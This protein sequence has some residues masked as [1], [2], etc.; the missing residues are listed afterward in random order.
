MQESR[1]SLKPPTDV[2]TCRPSIAFR[3]RS[4]LLIPEPMERETMKMV[5]NRRGLFW[6]LWI[7]QTLFTESLIV[8]SIYFT[9]RT[10]NHSHIFH[11]FYVDM[12]RTRIPGIMTSSSS[13][14]LSISHVVDSC[15]AESLLHLNLFCSLIL[16][17]KT[18]PIYK[19]TIIVFPLPHLL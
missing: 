11:C 13:S 10:W 5:L 4:Y 2:F 17:L 7:K 15:L 14:S 8:Y 12:N 19:T 9:L 6:F 16:H 1:K 3:Y 18:V